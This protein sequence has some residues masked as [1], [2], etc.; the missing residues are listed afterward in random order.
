MLEIAQIEKQ[1]FFEKKFKDFKVFVVLIIFQLLKK[2]MYE[3][4]GMYIKS[5]SEPSISTSKYEIFLLLLYHKSLCAR[6]FLVP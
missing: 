1:N 4:R 2:T 5:L 6:L 3:K